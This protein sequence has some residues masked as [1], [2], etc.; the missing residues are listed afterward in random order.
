MILC[1][2]V[3]TG[4]NLLLVCEVWIYYWAKYIETAARHERIWSKHASSHGCFIFFFF[5]FL[6]RICGT[7]HETYRNT[8]CRNGSRWTLPSI[9]TNS[10][11]VNLDTQRWTKKI[12]KTLTDFW[13]VCS[14]PM[15]M[16]VC[17]FGFNIFHFRSRYPRLL[18]LFK[19][20]SKSTCNIKVFVFSSSAVRGQRGY[21]SAARH[22]ARNSRQGLGAK[23]V[24][25]KFWT[26]QPFNLSTMTLVYVLLSVI[27]PQWTVSLERLLPL[28]CTR[29]SGGR[30]EYWG[31]SG[32]E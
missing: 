8:N 13:W 9:Q 17:P 14:I 31:N 28:T 16:A 19:P 5:F 27:S 18:N 12:G 29:R 23:L 21:V 10:F 15:D 1:V 24:R 26:V 3:T 6:A 30:G 32:M 2:T 25:R 11:V 22:M 20:H 4:H 7:V